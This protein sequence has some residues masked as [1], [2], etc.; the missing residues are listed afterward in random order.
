MSLHLFLS[1]ATVWPRVPNE[2]QAPGRRFTRA[3]S[4][5]PPNKPVHNCQ[6]GGEAEVTD[7]EQG[8]K[9]KGCYEAA[10]TDSKPPSVR[11]IGEEP[12]ESQ[13]AGWSGSEG[14]RKAESRGGLR[15]GKRA[16]S[17]GLSR[18]RPRPAPAPPPEPPRAPR[19][20]PPQPGPAQTHPGRR[21]TG[22]CGWRAAPPAPR[23][24]RDSAGSGSA[25]GSRGPGCSCSS[26]T[27][28]AGTAPAGGRG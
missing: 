3:L 20:P 24:R 16:L 9:E 2:N 25:R 11:M 28:S 23:G 22:S 21:C 7:A 4:L 17:E 18:P 12:N 1:P 6:P 19:L 10:L 14:V 27:C 26:R 5:S 8:R 15:V 13:E